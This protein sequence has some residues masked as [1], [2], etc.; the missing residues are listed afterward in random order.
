M[1]LTTHSFVYRR[2]GSTNA[3]STPLAYGSVTAPHRRMRAGA[4][5]ANGLVLWIRPSAVVAPTAELGLARSTKQ[6]DSAQ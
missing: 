2:R 1:I 5:T 6:W 3:S 4:R